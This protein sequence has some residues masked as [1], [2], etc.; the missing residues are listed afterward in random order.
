MDFFPE[1]FGK[2]AA[3]KAGL[4]PVSDLLMAVWRD[5]LAH[6]RTYLSLA[7]LT[8]LAF[9]FMAAGTLMAVVGIDADGTVLT[10]DPKN[11]ALFYAL[12]TIGVLVVIITNV[13]AQA[14]LNIAIANGG[15]NT[16]IAGAIRNASR[17]FWPFAATLVLLS[18]ILSVGFSLLFV[19]GV[20]FGTFLVFAEPAAAI[21]GLGPIES[22]KRSVRLVTGN[23][24]AI[25]WRVA[26]SVALLAAASVALS[27]P[28]EKI[29][30]IIIGRAFAD[31]LGVLRA[32][33]A[34]TLLIGAAI[35]ALILPLFVSLQ[36]HLFNEVKRKSPS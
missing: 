17:L 16:P 2:P 13:L 31:N 19:P 8:L 28:L 24:W 32:A 11:L 14:A 5:Y 3:P 22:L 35:T 18:I 25:L 9:P 33:L 30:T 4:S 26:V 21:E 6:A 36:V 15:K 23:F 34:V 12:T 10:S 7:A 1:R 29:P 20:I 27:F